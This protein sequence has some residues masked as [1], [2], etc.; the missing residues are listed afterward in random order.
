[1]T[2]TLAARPTDPA[3]PTDAPDDGDQ[4]HAGPR[5]V[6]GSAALYLVVSVGLWWGI[7]GHHPTST[8]TCG[9]GDAARFLWFFAWPPFALTHGHSV[10]YSQWLFHPTGINLLNDTSVLA[11]SVVLAPV[12]WLFG[13][14]A[15]MNVALTLAPALSALAM[16]LLLRRWVRWSPAAVFGGLVYGF[17]PFM[18]TELAYNQINIAFLAIPPLVV[19]ALD[20]LLVRQGRSPYR[21]GVAL[22]ALL[23]VQFF[24][25][26]EVLVITALMALVAV[27]VVAGYAAVREPGA[28]RA[29]AGHAARGAVTCLGAVAVALAYPA[30]FL[31]RGPAHLTGPIWSNGAIDQY[32]N[33]VASFWS[34]SGSAQL[35]GEM[36]RFGGYQGPALPGLGYLGPGTVVLSLVGLL[37]WRHDRRLWLF[38]SLGLVAGVLSLGPGHGYWVPW[39]AVDRLPWVGD[40]VEIRFTLVLTVCLAIMAAVA[41][42]RVH[43]WGAA[44]RPPVAWPR[45]AVMAVGLAVVA[46][47]PSLVALWPNLP[48]TAQSVVLP[49]WYRQVGATLP[50]GQVVLSYPAPFAGVQSP[51]AWQAVTSMRYALAGGGGPGGVASRAGDA[52]A[53]FRVLFDASFALGPAPEPTAANLA[54]IRHALT[55]WGV[56]MVVVPDQPGLPAY[57]QGRSTALAVGL[58]TAALGAA[59]RYDRSAWVW[60]SVVTTGAPVPLTGARFTTCTTGAVAAAASRQSVASCVLAEPGTAG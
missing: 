33:T 15:A 56:T 40:I 9:C 13:P 37:I 17:S 55:L 16:L 11:L 5:V 32:G 44:L 23:V 14:V 58:F 3:V 27:A 2:E 28:I 26:T 24:V 45:A 47:V 38:G 12:T 42:D 25:S 7:W 54:A 36:Q 43:T 31:L 46:V 60:S 6:A 48:L 34:G 21:T 1:M 20:E 30:W 50:P 52:Q 29:R 8:T 19:L 35:V 59:P 41:V 39:Q 22:A 18:V 51:M 53:G 57:D 10:L 4:R 49:E